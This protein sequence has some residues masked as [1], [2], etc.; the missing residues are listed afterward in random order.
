MRASPLILAIG[1]VAVGWASG[2]G[3]AQILFSLFG[4]VVFQRGPTGIG[5][6]WG[7]A[8]VGLVCGAMRGARIGRRLSFNGY[9][10]T[11]SIAT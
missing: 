4:E 10:R 9:K 6:I 3:A 2:G 11:I 5:I 8:G 1:L 7:C